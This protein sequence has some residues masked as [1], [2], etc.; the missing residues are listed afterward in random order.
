[1]KGARKH[2]AIVE[3]YAGLV[4][5][6]GEEPGECRSA[7]GLGLPLDAIV[8]A[9]E[10][11]LTILDWGAWRRYEALPGS[12]LQ[13]MPAPVT[14]PL[15]SPAALGDR[16]RAASPGVRRL[17]IPAR[18][19]AHG[20]SF[21]AGLSPRSH[22][23]LADSDPL[24][25]ASYCL[26]RELVA[27][28][29]HDPL[30]L[31]L[32]PMWGGCG[33][34][35]QLG[36]ATGANPLHG[37]AIMVV[38]TDTSANRQ[39]ANLEGLWT[40]PA[41]TRRQ[42]EDLSLALADHV[43][44]FGP[45]GEAVA[46]AGRLPESPPPVTA[47]RTVPTDRLEA[48]GEAAGAAR[49]GGPRQLFL[50]EP[51]DGASGVQAALDAVAILRRKG[52]RLERPLV[53]AG[54]DMTL[55][56]MKPRGF[57]E[58]WSSRGFVRE[59][60]AERQWEWAE[61][62]RPPESAFPVRL[63]PS[64]FEHLP[65]VW[66]ELAQGS[67]VLLSPGA[68]EGLAPGEIL[69]EE[70]LIG[71]EPTPHLLAERLESLLRAEVGR[72]D[73]ARRELCS[74]VVAAHRGQAWSRLLG[75]TVAALG[76]IL[77]RPPKPPSLSRAAMLLLDRRQSL[78]SLAEIR[79]P[80]PPTSP[81]PRRLTVVVTCYEMGGQIEETMGS[82]WRS[83]R[84]PDEVLLVDDGSDGEATRMSLRALER[85]AEARGLP[86][87]V[88]RQRN[89]GLAAA[90][91]AGLAA[92]SGD[93]ISFLDG[94]DIIDPAFY[95][96]ALRIIEEH[97]DLGGVAAWSLVFGSEAPDAFWNA[98]QPELP[99][100]LVENTVIVPCMMRTAVLRGLGGYDTRLRFNYEDWELSIR[101]VASGRPI[102]TIPAYLQ[103]YRVRS[104]SL[105]RTM[106]DVQ[107]QV[108]RELILEIHRE[109]VS[110]F[111]LET[112]MQLENQ[113]A[114]RLWATPPVKI[115]SAGS[116]RMIGL[117]RRVWLTLASVGSRR[118]LDR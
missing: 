74:R 70:A 33:Y 7:L 55:A 99:L 83:E 28:H 90:R 81:G 85:Q 73:Q 111:A 86:L 1:M 77:A 37:I 21:A 63:Y 23:L 100:L 115:G 89:Q 24:F 29:A 59:L 38:V 27:L 48:I 31:L 78:R 8:E 68:A 107:N 96:L 17:Q 39:R 22:G 62:Y 101:L 69:P 13:W 6:L 14:R 30:D 106:S 25:F 2:V 93:F 84:L 41:L 95:R 54:P 80:S 11:R 50:V 102:V 67:L 88:I 16:D 58:Y 94:D 64:I 56:P 110:R 82:V 112:A 76:E 49:P 105:Y 71:R 87:R 104:D 5:F 3:T 60:V 40:R 46:L 12:F 92:A 26:E 98:P 47:P 72:L 9:L 35:A 44:V 61:R 113:L 108:M 32:I 103:R 75:E 51:Q 34:V 118:R 36:R 42:M 18:D 79:P 43:L 57:V 91:N 65:D 117:A 52:V 116:Q 66:S 19:P 4:E 45:R 53:S 114:K 15:R 20:L 109:T 10:C 97:P